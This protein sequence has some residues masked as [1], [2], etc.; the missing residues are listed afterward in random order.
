MSKEI[1]P[2]GNMNGFTHIVTAVEVENEDRQTRKWI[3]F[4][5]RN[6]ILILHVIFFMNLERSYECLGTQGC[7]WYT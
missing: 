6:I 7:L 5:L 2:T 1:L 4:D 3:K